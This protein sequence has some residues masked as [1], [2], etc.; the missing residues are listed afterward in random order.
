[1][2]M[3]ELIGLRILTAED[4]LLTIGSIISYIWWFCLVIFIIKAVITKSPLDRKKRNMIAIKCIVARIWG[5][6]GLFII[7]D[8]NKLF[9]SNSY[10][11]W[12]ALQAFYIVMIISLY[13]ILL[14][15]SGNPLIF[16][17]KEVKYSWP[18][19]FLNMQEQCQGDGIVDNTSNLR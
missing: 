16:R 2:N 18:L 17:K 5:Y 6:V 3:Q 14:F 11:E 1:M 19:N 13:G 15:Y 10:F 8:A 4:Y 12:F 9:P 7:K